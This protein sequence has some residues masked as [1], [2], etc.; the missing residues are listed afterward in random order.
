MR[1]ENVGRASLSWSNRKIG[2]EKRIYFGKLGEWLATFEGEPGW[3]ELFCWLSSFKIT[4]MLFLCIARN[5]LMGAGEEAFTW[6]RKSNNYF[7][8][9][10]QFICPIESPPECHVCTIEML[11]CWRGRVWLSPGSNWEC[12]RTIWLRLCWDW[13]LNRSLIPDLCAI[14][15]FVIRIMWKSVDGWDPGKNHYLLF[16]GI[17]EFL[18]NFSPDSYTQLPPWPI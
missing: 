4:F 5:L 1:A 10:H 16:W 6:N 11:E 18:I 8:L 9:I 2:V 13:S 15:S 7:F 17:L 14:Y 3:G 12:L